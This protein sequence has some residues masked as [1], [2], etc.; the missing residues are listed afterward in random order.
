M[1]LA[2]IL[3]LMPTSAA[4]FIQCHR[5]PARN[6]RGDFL[7]LSDSRVG[8][9]TDLSEDHLIMT[10]G[11]LSRLA[12]GDG[13]AMNECINQY[14]NL[15][16]S[17]VRRCFLD[18]ASAEDVVQEI[19]TEIWTKA[20]TYKPEIAGESTWIALIARRRTID[21]YRKLTRR[22]VMEEL[23]DPEILGAESSD[24]A[25]VPSL[26]R[27]E[28]TRLLQRLP[29]TTRIMIEMALHDGFTHQEIADKLKQPLGTVKT[30]I[31]RGLLELRDIIVSQSGTDTDISSTLTK[32][33]DR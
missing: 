10:E 33:E 18:P 5:T 2:E 9:E 23:P 1:P 21:A 22:P 30:R 8:L 6:H 25:P 29:D 19:F 31:R 12:N 13:Q 24:A 17:I 27:E 26:S 15:V 3:S 7:N 4:R 28:A 14:G 11:L 16:W 20:S 32:G